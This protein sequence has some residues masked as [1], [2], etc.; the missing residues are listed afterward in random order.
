MKHAETI[1]AF[2]HHIRQVATFLG[3]QETANIRSP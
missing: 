3:Y 2:V 1:D